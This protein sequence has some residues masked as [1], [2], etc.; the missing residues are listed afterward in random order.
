M[1]VSIY[2]IVNLVEQTHAQ[3]EAKP[4]APVILIAYFGLQPPVSR[5]KDIVAI[6]I[7]SYRSQMP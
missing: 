6:E 3:C 1:N 4:Y 2:A 5:E 7:Q